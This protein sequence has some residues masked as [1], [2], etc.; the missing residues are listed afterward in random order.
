MISRFVGTLIDSS[1][2]DHSWLGG[3]NL[4]EPVFLPYKLKDVHA[5]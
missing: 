3:D 5:L 4:Y 2:L 1:C